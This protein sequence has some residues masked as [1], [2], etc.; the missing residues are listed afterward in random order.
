MMR[1][2]LSL[3]LLTVTTAVADDVLDFPIYPG[4]TLVEQSDDESARAYDF[5]LS[6]VE[7]I[8]RELKIENVL[9]V[10][11][12]RSS[13]TYQLP[14]SASLSAV[15]AHYAEVLPVADV[16]FQC[17]GRDCGRSNQWANQVFGLPILYGPDAQQYYVAGEADGDLVSVYL[18]QRGNR[19]IYAHLVRLTPDDQ[20]EVVANERLVQQLTSQGHTVVRG[21]TPARDGRLD[22]AAL[23]RLSELGRAIASLR[24]DAVVVVCH[25]YDPGALDA[26][27]ERSSECAEAAR[28]ALAEGGGDVEFIAFGA[29][30]LLPRE[31]ENR[32]RIELVTP[33][34]LHRE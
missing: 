5:V 10:S 3:T 29:G 26:Q 1:W 6:P 24:T 27:L 13:R 16:R 25:L 15:I 11:A 19:R 34:R 9:R 17:R 28:A 4:A 23:S 30:P 20:V 31:A 18:I 12:R 14:S 8:R 22:T 7:K 21:V 2:L 33:H 32:S